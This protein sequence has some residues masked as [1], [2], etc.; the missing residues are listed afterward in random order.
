MDKLI[1][2]CYRHGFG[3]ENLSYRISQHPCCEPLEVSYDQGRTVIK[4]E[5]FDK[6]FLGFNKN[7]KYGF[8]SNHE[9]ICKN[10]Y[11]EYFKKINKQKKFNVIPSHLSYTELIKTFKNSF[12]VIITPPKKSLRKK[13]LNHIYKNFWQYKANSVIETVGQ[14]YCRIEFLYEKDATVDILKKKTAE[15]LKK[16]KNRLNFGEIYCVLSNMEPTEANCK[17]LFLQQCKR[18]VFRYKKIKI[19][20]QPN[21]LY[22]PYESVKTYDIKKIF[23][24]F[25]IS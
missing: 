19:N 15:I 7:F 14:I 24:F 16:Y 6:I 13:Y 18:G 12:Y 10:V 11:T 23:Q 17:K 5:F 8:F 3:G 25:N 9:N 1:F 20:T 4:E 21:I 2:V 22:I